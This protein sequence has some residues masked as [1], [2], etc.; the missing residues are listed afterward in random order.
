M[1][2]RIL[3]LVLHQIPSKIQ[4]AASSSSLKPNSVF[5]HMNMHKK[6]EDII[7]L[8]KIYQCKIA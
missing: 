1:V 7:I 2:K 8:R 3:K 6:T 5:I 4:A